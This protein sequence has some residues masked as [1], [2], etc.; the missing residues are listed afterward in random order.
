[1]GLATKRSLSGGYLW[2]LRVIGF[3]FAIY[4][5]YGAVNGSA[6]VFGPASWNLF[7]ISFPYIPYFGEQFSLT[8]FIFFTT[9][10]TFLLYPARE[11]SPKDRPSAVDL[12]FCV[13][14]FAI[15]VE[16]IYF[17]DFRGA[18]AGLVPPWNDVVFGLTAAILV[19]EACRRVLGLILP[20][21]AIVFLF[22]D[23]MGPYF[24]GLFS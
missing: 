1:M 19:W 14:S 20:I 10:L 3:V 7:K 18:T 4:F 11:S 15:V 5:L 9:V 22:Y 24:P 12:T 17:Y 21:V 8:L 6:T 23:W 13:L 2:F 16:Y